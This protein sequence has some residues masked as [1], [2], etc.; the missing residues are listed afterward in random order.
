M[1]RDQGLHMPDV[2]L[3]RWRLLLV[4]VVLGGLAGVWAVLAIAD[5][6]PGVPAAATVAWTFEPLERGAII[7]TP[8]VTDAHVYVA[9][10]HEAGFAAGGTV[11]CLE[12]ATRKVMWKFDDDGDMQHMVSSPCLAGGRLYLGEGM[13]ANHVCKFYCLDAT[14]GRKHWHFVTAGHIESS[15][16]VVDGNVFFCSGDDGLYCLDALTGAARWHY[17]P[18]LHMDTSPAVSGKRLFAGSGVSRN[19]KATAAFCLDTVD[20]QVLWQVPTDLPVW[21]SPA[22]DGD[23]AFFGLGNGRLV[24]SVEP[25]ERPAGAV[26]CLEAITGRRCWRHNVSDAVMARPTVARGR[27]YFGSRDGHCYCVDQANGQ[28]CWKADLGSPVVTTPAVVGDQLYV[29]SSGGRVCR[30]DADK[31]NVLW[32]FDVAEHSHTRPQL[33]SSPVVIPGPGAGGHAGIYFGTEL[34]SAVNSAAVLYCL[35]D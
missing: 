24:Q 30:L 8:C 22:V 35:Q 4:V 31:G 16:C 9:A 25:P 10:I 17:R 3:R 34:R 5:R 13:H 20:G 28:L 11:Y 2:K 14:S 18:P 6:L 7:T 21:G 1:H 32:A 23:H 29:V 19:Y 33:L 27:V 26:L 15:P 12:R